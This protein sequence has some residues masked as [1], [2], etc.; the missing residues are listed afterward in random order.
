MLNMTAA[1][2]CP[3]RNFVVMLGWTAPNGISVPE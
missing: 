3:K 1:P 2:S